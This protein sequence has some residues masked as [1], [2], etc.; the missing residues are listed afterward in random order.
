ML[1]LGWLM[2]HWVG[3]TVAGF[4]MS[5]LGYD[6]PSLPRQ[7]QE[8]RPEPRGRPPGLPPHRNFITTNCRMLRED[9]SSTSSREPSSQ[10]REALRI[11]I[12]RDS[13]RPWF[14]KPG[15]RIGVVRRTTRAPPMIPSEP[16]PPWDSQCPPS[17]DPQG[18]FYKKRW[19]KKIQFNKKAL[20]RNIVYEPVFRKHFHHF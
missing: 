10:V 16:A 12:A 2:L 17:C 1:H 11:S 14:A 3:K 13:M 6:E 7:N 9:G 5:G 4:V 18:P 8:V 19:K 20:K 15:D